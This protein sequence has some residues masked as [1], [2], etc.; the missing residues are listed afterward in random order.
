MKSLCGELDGGK[1]AAPITKY[2]TGEWK[3]KRTALCLAI[4]FLASTAM[5]QES[6]KKDDKKLNMAGDWTIKSGTRSGNAIGADRLSDVKIS[7]KTFTLPAG[8]DDSFVMAY[9][10]DTSKKPNTIDF[11]IESGPVPEGKAIGIIKMDKGG[12]TIC[13]DPT[14]QKRPEKFETDEENGFFLFKLERKESKFDAK[15]MV[16]NWA[17]VSGKRAGAD[18]AEERLAAVVKVSEKTFTMP[19]GPDAS[20]VMKY[21]IESSK[22]PVQIDLEIESGP[23]PEGKAIGIVKMDGDKMVLC[24][25]PTG[26][27]R[28]EKFETSED[29]GFF[30]FVMKPVKEE[31]KKDK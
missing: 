25:D 10:V 31:K 6:S 2:K 11:E 8:P 22:S 29:D 24:Y 27:T 4:V 9:K 26:Q 7:E 3:M 23:V 5:A 18:V 30:M 20:F 16:G 1:I 14:G 17:L 13:Y 21:E 15:K 28:P 19:A 12:M